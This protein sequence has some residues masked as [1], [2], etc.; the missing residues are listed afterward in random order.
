[1]YAE[2]YIHLFLSPQVATVGETLAGGYIEHKN[3]VKPDTSAAVDKSSSDA[4]GDSTKWDRFW[5]Q[6]ITVT[7]KEGKL[8]HVEF[9]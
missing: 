2:Y 6:R 1:M 4:A 5:N 9:S 3:E 8:F 7:M